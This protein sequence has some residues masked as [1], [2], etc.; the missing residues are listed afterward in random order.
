[1]RLFIFEDPDGVGQWV[2][3]YVMNRINEFAPT[4]E[5]PFV[6][7]LPTGE[8]LVGEGRALLQTDMTA[9]CRAAGA[10]RCSC[11]PPA[12]LPAW[13][14]AGSCCGRQAALFSQRCAPHRL[15][16]GKAIA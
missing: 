16:C 10:A 8:W 9:D 12:V 13:A 7:G 14:L 6:L 1:M 3:E 11:H 5:K 4:A 2:A 15:R